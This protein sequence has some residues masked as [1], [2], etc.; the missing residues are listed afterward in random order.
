MYIDEGTNKPF[1]NQNQN[2]N[3]N[4]SSPHLNLAISLAI[5]S[6]LTLPRP[7]SPFFVPKH[8]FILINYYISYI[9]Y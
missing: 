2:Q 9:K 1:K 3:Q 7:L 8:F 5:F 6:T 4:Q